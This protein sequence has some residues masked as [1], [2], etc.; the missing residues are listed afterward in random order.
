MLLEQHGFQ[1]SQRIIHFGNECRVWFATDVTV[2]V[3]EYLAKQ[4][5][6]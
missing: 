1:L 6:R 2:C 5:G 4:W 3:C